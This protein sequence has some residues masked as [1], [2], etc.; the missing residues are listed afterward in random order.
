MST[1]DDGYRGIWFTLGQFSEFGD[2]YSGGLGTY[3]ANHV[4]MAVYAPAVDKTFFTYG[5]RAKGDQHLRILVSFFDHKTGQVPRPRIVHDKIGV[6][7]PHD[8]ASLCL[9]DKGHVWVFV[10]GRAKA[11]PGFKY[12]SRAPYDIA[13]FELVSEEEITYPQPWFHADK[14]FLHLF[15]KYTGRR[16]NGRQL[17]WQTS[18]DGKAW[19]AH[20]QL[21]DLEGHYQVSNLRADGVIGSFFNVHPDGDVDQRTNVYYVQTS[22]WGATW[23]TVN[24]KPLVLPLKSNDNPALVL[25]LKSKGELMY[26]DD[27]NFD[28]AGNPL[29]LY[30]RSRRAAPGPPGQLR[31]L[32]LTRWTGKDWRTG[33]VCQ[34]DHN[35]DTG[36]L[37]I[38]GDEWTIIAPTLPGPQ[39]LQGGGELCLYASRDAGESWTLKQQITKSSRFN[40]NYAR[41]PQNA[42]DPF[43]CFWADGDPTKLSPSRLYFCDSTGE[44]VRQLPYDMTGEFARP[45]EVT[46]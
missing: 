42:R 32:C 45:V 38:K 25:D 24:N 22:D 19:S 17:Y 2:K 34:T 13:D 12:R 6:N 1:H 40:H 23:T 9:D 44:H 28:R 39:P 11:R 14:G 26:T 8:N 27:L 20:H 3:T 18:R 35:Y 46:P 30:V 21:S 41:R 5:G 37:Y 29:L 16:R 36:S 10:S 43:F 15:T 33:V 7:D 31:D 4:P